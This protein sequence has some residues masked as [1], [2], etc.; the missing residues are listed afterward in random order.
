MVDGLYKEIAILKGDLYIVYNLTP[1]TA[2]LMYQI[3]I[4]NRKLD[5][6]D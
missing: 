2:D 6:L 4:I 3:T 1:T 5:V